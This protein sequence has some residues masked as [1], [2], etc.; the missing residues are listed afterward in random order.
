MRKIGGCSSSPVLSPEP[1]LASTWLSNAFLRMP[2]PAARAVSTPT[3]LPS[4]TTAT[5]GKHRICLNISLNTPLLEG[6]PYVFGRTSFRAS[7]SPKCPFR[8]ATTSKTAVATIRGARVGCFGYS[9]NGFHAR[10]FAPKGQGRWQKARPDQPTSLLP[11]SPGGGAPRPWS[12]PV[13]GRRRARQSH[14]S[15]GS[16]ASEIPTSSGPRSRAM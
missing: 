11:D 4:T 9:E 3:T 14:V 6:L 8:T 1:L 13:R 16:L 5:E 2:K 10:V 12:A 15:S 7:D